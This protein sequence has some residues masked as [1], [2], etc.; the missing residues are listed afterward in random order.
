MNKSD[1]T[2]NLP[3]ELSTPSMEGMDGSDA[4]EP[5]D[6]TPASGRPGGRRFKPSRPLVAVVI[7]LLACL[8]VIY[9]LFS[10]RS[11]TVD[12]VPLTEQLEIDGG[13]VLPVGN[14]YLLLPGAYTVEAMA[15][16]YYPLRESFV[17]TAETG[18]EFVFEMV[19][20]PDILNINSTP[21]SEATVI[22]DGQTVGQ[23][24]LI[25][26]ELT[27]GEHQLE[28]TAP[29]YQTYS[30]SLNLDGGGNRLELTADLLPA[31]SE[32]SFES[33]PPGAAIS[34]DGEESALTPATVE[35]L[36]GRRDIRIS[37]PGHKSWEG[38]LE[39]PANE[40]IE[41]PA[42]EL[43]VVD[44]Q[45]LV[46][47]RPGNANILV[48]DQFAGQSELELELAPGK[49]YRIEAFKTGYQNASGTVNIV[50][51]QEQTLTLTLQAELGEIVIRTKPED[52]AIRI[53]G[54]E[55]QL[56]GGKIALP[57]VPQR[58]TVSRA[59][60]VDFQTT[61]TP[62]PGF[63]QQIDAILKTEEQAKWEAVKPQLTTSAGQTLKLIRAGQ[64]TMGASRREAGR[65]ANET[66]RE[67]DLPRPFYLA[68]RE[69]TN[70]QYREFKASHSS[71]RA[72]RFSLNGDDQPVVKVTW[73]DAARY[74]NW[75]S[76]RD[77]LTPVYRFSGEVLQNFDP[78]AT[79]YRL[80]TE[81]EWAWVARVTIDG[82]L[83]FPW[84][85]LFPPTGKAGNFADHSAS[86]FLGRVIPGYDDGFAASAPVGSFPP[87]AAGFYDLGG[88]VSEWIH[89]F[90]GQV[91]K[92]S[93]R[94]EK[95]P[96]GPTNG[97]FHVIRDSSW[98]HG[99]VVELRLSFRDY[100]DKARDDLGFRIARYVF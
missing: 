77:G 25:D 94:V 64:F 2:E 18:Q 35:I 33:I 88:N 66:L 76:Q 37:L 59:G 14:R 36:Q 68:T 45:L 65:R 26:F 56:T 22:V 11:I 19:L 71:Q 6:F 97:K 13:P 60:F 48:N 15:E 49:S 95:D 53:N 51:G 98:R 100:G 74:C 57:A 91:T 84:G 72:D 27:S 86:L 67:V 30:E 29:R 70:A 16:R 20:L 43:E 46:I 52:A 23:T 73:E 92:A 28:L 79:G 9:F 75:L 99:S 87:N 38:R 31:W 80:P 89:D 10:A 12:T 17:V 39:I 40:K 5:A 62:K 21:V 3:D 93:G 96:M 8:P 4:I 78:Q 32:V 81:A 63:T 42:V 69:V 90:Y 85:D 44:G 83:K 82:Q 47:T 58:I 34:I 54:R 7:A 1:K 55:K 41:V 61:I 24:P 50:S